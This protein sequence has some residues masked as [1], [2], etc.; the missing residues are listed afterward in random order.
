MESFSRINSFLPNDWRENW[1][2][3]DPY[4]MYLLTV[5]NYY[6]TERRIEGKFYVIMDSYEITDDDCLWLTMNFD[7]KD[8]FFLRIKYEYK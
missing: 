1:K 7:V 2:K 3:Y 5:N 4:H 6:V 8:E